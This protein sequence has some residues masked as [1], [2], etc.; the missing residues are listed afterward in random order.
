MDEKP[1]VGIQLQTG[2]VWM[3]KNL[4]HK[5]MPQIGIIYN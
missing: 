5:G 2:T 3:A 1:S 4:L